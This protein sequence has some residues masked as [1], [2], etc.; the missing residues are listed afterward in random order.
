[1]RR[2]EIPRFLRELRG[3]MGITAT[4]L[5]KYFGV[6]MST[7]CKWEKGALPN[8]PH[9]HHIMYQLALDKT[10]VY[11]FFRYKPTTTPDRTLDEVKRHIEILQKEYEK[12]RRQEL[13]KDDSKF[14]VVIELQYRELLQE[15]LDKSHQ[16]LSNYI[17]SLILK[18]L[19]RITS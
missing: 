15:H 3:E 10:P 8:E 18:D 14:T 6:H 7:V 16:N 17:T 13:F 2:T 4:E 12:L 1:M 19:E 9:R 5:A 11:N